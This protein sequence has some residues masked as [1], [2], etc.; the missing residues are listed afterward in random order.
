[1]AAAWITCI[2]LAYMVTALLIYV[3]TVCILTVVADK[4]AACIQASSEARQCDNDLSDPGTNLAALDVD[5]SSQ[6]QPHQVLL[7]VYNVLDLST[8]LK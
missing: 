4:D 3:I 2:I 7:S 8:T 6:F 5:C 1:M